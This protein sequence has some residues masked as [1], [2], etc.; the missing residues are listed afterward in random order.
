[1]SRSSPSH[2]DA[3][4]ILDMLDFCRSDAPKRNPI[5]LLTHITSS[6]CATELRVNPLADPD[7][8]PMSPIAIETLKDLKLE[9]KEKKPDE[10][11]VEEG[12]D[13]DEEEMEGA[14]G[15]AGG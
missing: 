3:Q 11:E 14:D 6:E 9:D 1:M 12:D 10:V 4:V 5:R 8:A 2:H 13:D 7:A 15:A